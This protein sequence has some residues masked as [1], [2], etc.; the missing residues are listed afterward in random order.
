[1][2]GE[3]FKH[4]VW[5]ESFEFQLLSELRD[6]RHWLSAMSQNRNRNRSATSSLR[7]AMTE[8]P[9]PALKI[10]VRP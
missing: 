3:R 2:F 6:N 8:T 10:Q 4:L 5:A 1:M 7:T 9:S